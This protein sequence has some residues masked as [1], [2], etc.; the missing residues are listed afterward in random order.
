MNKLFKTLWSESRQTY[1]VTNETQRTH[2]K[3]KTC[4]LAV[5]VTLSALLALPAQAYV[6][7][8]KWQTVRQQ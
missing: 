6:K 7:K 2:G 4:V 3:P 5:A 8:V 1:V